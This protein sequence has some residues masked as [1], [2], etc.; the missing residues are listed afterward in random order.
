MNTIQGIE[1]RS[2]DRKGHGGVPRRKG[3]EYLDLERCRSAP[4]GF[5]SCQLPNYF[6]ALHCRLALVGVGG[7]GTLDR[8]A[9][10]SGLLEC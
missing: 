9:V 8:T 2:A 3:K 6:T 5:C 1:C 10:L 7:T 4:S